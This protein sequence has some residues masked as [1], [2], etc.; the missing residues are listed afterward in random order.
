MEKH[1][2]HTRVIKFLSEKNGIVVKVL[3]QYARKYADVIESMPNVKSY[4]TLKI[5]DKDRY[6]FINTVDIRKEYFDADWQTD[7]VL[8]YNDGSIGIRELVLYDY[9]YKRSTIEQLEMSRRYWMS[10]DISDW[11]VVVIKGEK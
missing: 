2:K 11:K 1:R 3:T 8:Y 10:T 4:E 7:F 5:L 6:N 9:L